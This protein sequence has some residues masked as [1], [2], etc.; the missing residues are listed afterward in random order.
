MPGLEDKQIPNI[1]KENDSL[2]GDTGLEGIPIPPNGQIANPT[3][4]EFADGN[5]APRPQK[6]KVG[7]E[8]FATP[9]GDLGK[10]SFRGDGLA[11]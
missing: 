10:K 3:F 11:K 5:D 7:L 4:T 2:G 6:G 8:D 9:T 1:P